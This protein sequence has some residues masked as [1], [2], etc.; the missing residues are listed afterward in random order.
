MVLERIKMTV[1]NRALTRWVACW[2]VLLMMVSLLPSTGVIAQQPPVPPDEYGKCW[3][4]DGNRIPAP[5]TNGNTC[6]VRDGTLCTPMTCGPAGLNPN[7]QL[8]CGA[9]CPNFRPTISAT[10]GFCQLIGETQGRCPGCAQTGI[11]ANN[12]VVP[13]WIVCAYGQNFQDANCKEE[14]DCWSYRAVRT[15][16]DRNCFIR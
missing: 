7:G 12:Q 16:N 11:D 10:L 9:A 3:G 14:C 8:P 1:W 4:P 6:Q 15:T 5:N 13:V 2:L